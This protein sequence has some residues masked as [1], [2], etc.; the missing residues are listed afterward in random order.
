MNGR[1]WFPGNPWPD[2]H[3]II[4]L[5]F[6]ILLHDAGLGLLLN[7]RS[8]DYGIHDPDD[9]D[10]EDE[11]DDT[12]DWE[13]KI[14]WN[15]YHACTLSNT[16]WGIEPATCPVIDPAGFTAN[17]LD[18]LTFGPDPVLQGQELAQDYDQNAFHIYLLGHDAVAAHQIALDRQPDGHFALT[19]SGLI[20]LA[21]G[22]YYDFDYLFRAEARNV[23][24]LGFHVDPGPDRPD[25]RPSVEEREQRAQ[26]LRA[27][28]LADFGSLHF[29]AGEE[30]EPDYLVPASNQ[31]T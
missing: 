3:A 19:W 29:N 15:N 30:W 10:D 28:F 9:D 6:S 24:F 1:I 22:G 7:L 31:K 11:P 25:V 27:Q 5:A 8:E 16:Y 23:P 2:G 13:S 21:Y 26:T 4:A 14:V 18:R 12:R 20:A 17:R